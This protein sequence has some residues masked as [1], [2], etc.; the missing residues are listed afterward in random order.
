MKLLLKFNEVKQSDKQI[1]ILEK[2]NSIW[3]Y[4]LGISAGKEKARLL[5]Q[6]YPENMTCI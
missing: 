6:H 5:I 1:Q 3:F 2:Q 4:P